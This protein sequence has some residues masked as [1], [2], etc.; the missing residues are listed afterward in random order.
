MVHVQVER[1]V[2][3]QQVAVGSCASTG[4]WLGPAASRIVE[5]GVMALSAACELGTDRPRGGIGCLYPGRHPG[6]ACKLP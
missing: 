1:V 6:R 3:V 4:V 2:L 5:N